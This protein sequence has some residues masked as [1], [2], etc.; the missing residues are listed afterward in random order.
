[1]A[2]KNQKQNTQ[3]KKITENKPMCCVCYPKSKQAGEKGQMQPGNNLNAFLFAI[4][5]F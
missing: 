1:M 4:A 2:T 3:A 5:C